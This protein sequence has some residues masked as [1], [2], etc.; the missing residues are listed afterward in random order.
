M[1]RIRN[2]SFISYTV[3]HL[4]IP[5]MEL[6][7]IAGI[8]N[9]IHKRLVLCCAPDERVP[10]HFVLQPDFRLYHNIYFPEPLSQQRNMKELSF[11]RTSFVPAQNKGNQTPNAIYNHQH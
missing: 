11:P 6:P 2:G 5:L 10:G 3:I 7:S 8:V 1:S 9:K 4:W